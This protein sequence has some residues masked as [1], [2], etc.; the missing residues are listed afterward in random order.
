M[1]KKIKIS[2]IIPTLNEEKY[3]PGLLK[4]I[5]LQSF[6]DYEVIV[7]DAHSQD[8]T[9]EIAKE[10]GV[11]AVK[12]GMPA[13][14]RNNG[15]AVAKG[16]FI[17]FLDADVE[18]PPD[19]LEKAYNEMR[20]RHLELA[21]CEFIPL[22]DLLI[23]KVMHSFANLFIK[24]NLSI[25]PHAAGFC[26]FVSKELFEKVGGFNESLK[27]AEDHDFVKRATKHSPLGVL[28]STKIE[29]SVRRLEKEGRIVLF[30]KY[31]KS[32]LQRLIGHKVKISDIEY[33][34]GK[35]NHSGQKTPESHLREFENSLIRLNMAYNRLVARSGKSDEKLNK[36]LMKLRKLFQEKVRQFRDFI[37]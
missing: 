10:Y 35:Y 2:I 28:H 18:I 25:N 6:K 27:M 5:K 13:V 29:V 24:L 20:V 31:F 21:T 33:E 26:I 19:F 1:E 4:T 12:G 9:V 22:S 23:D 37:R 14:G 17:F 8:K 11:K 34:F 32:G 16:D 30:G 36:E 15:A 7:A 3:L